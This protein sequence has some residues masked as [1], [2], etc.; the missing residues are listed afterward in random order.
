MPSPPTLSAIVFAQETT[1]DLDEVIALYRDSTLGARRPI[2]DRAI[3]A[4]MYAHANL[5]ITARHNG[6]LVGVSRSLTDFS[7]V[8][9][10]SDLAVHAD[11]QR[12]GIG[13]E[14]MRQTQSRMGPRSTIVLLAAPA[15]T[16]YYP[17]VGFTKVDSA[18]IAKASDPIGRNGSPHRV[19]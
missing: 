17:K 19:P 9:Y 4:D 18:W 13:E 7:Y 14:L 8:A 6:A 15:A 1:F 3:V 5:I 10:L 12:I 11:Y 2:D 16:G